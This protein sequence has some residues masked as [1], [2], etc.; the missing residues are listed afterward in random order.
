MNINQTQK[1]PKTF[2]FK[3]K[4]IFSVVAFAMLFQ[5]AIFLNMTVELSLI[6]KVILGLLPVIPFIYAIINLTSSIKQDDEMFKKIIIDA[7]N[8]TGLITMSWTLAVGLLQQLAVL[9]YFS[10]YFVFFIMCLTFSIS[11]FL[12]TKK[13]Q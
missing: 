6:W 4:F 1:T 11:V 13:Y 2:R 5:S 9:P 3:K 12:T 7:F 10:L 8:L